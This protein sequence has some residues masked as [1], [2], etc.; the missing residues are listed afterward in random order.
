[1]ASRLLRMTNDQDTCKHKL[2]ALRN[3]LSEGNLGLASDT[4]GIV[5]PELPSS[6]RRRS[7]EM[8]VCRKHQIRSREN[9]PKNRNAYLLAL[10]VNVNRT[11]LLKSIER[12]VPLRLIDR[13][14]TG[15]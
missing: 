5:F 1:M 11:L 4:V 15:S 2:G 14:I 7:Q 6:V 13:G 3:G 10:V 12:V 8:M 9:E